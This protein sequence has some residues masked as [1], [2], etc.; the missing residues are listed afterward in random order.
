MHGGRLLDGLGGIHAVAQEGYLVV[1]EDQPPAREVAFLE[2]PATACRD[3]FSKLFCCV[4]ED[5]QERYTLRGYRDFG[6]LV[7]RSVANTWKAIV[8]IVASRDNNGKLSARIDLVHLGYLKMFSIAHLVDA[9]L[10]S[11]WIEVFGHM[12]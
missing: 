10:A 3:R 9:L 6:L 8:G 2:G 5:L 4:G 12:G 1:G 7:T 11:A